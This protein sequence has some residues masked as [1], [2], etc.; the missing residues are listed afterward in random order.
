MNMTIPYILTGLIAI[1]LIT[2]AVKNTRKKKASKTDSDETTKKLKWWSP[3]RLSLKGALAII[4]GLTLF[5]V[6]IGLAQLPFKEDT[7]P[8]E[9]GH[10][11][12]LSELTRG[13]TYEVCAFGTGHPGKTYI[14]LNGKDQ[15]G[16]AYTFENTP[17]IMV[18]APEGGTRRELRV[19][20]G[21]KLYDIDGNDTGYT[22][23]DFQPYHIKL[24]GG[25]HYRV[26]SGTITVVNELNDYEKER[27]KK[28][29]R[30]S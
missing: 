28:R 24:G 23:R 25:G 17:I 1:M 11:H 6:L 18:Y 13:E 9:D 4:G 27:M 5:W 30:K 22:L 2:L 19:F 26:P 21:N 20:Q 29:K 3:R 10:S 14:R 12:T 7:V 15:K 8:V 16:R